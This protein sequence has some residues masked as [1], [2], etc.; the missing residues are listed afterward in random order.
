MGTGLAAVVDR[1]EGDGAVIRTTDGQEL[2]IHK[3]QLPTGTREGVALQ[4]TFTANKSA[5]DKR[6]KVA[7]HLLS[8][9]KGKI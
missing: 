1:W 4:I 2:F 8:N 3:S 9:I 6:N 5:T 7:R